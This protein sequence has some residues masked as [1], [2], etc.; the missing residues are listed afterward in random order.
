VT[1]ANTGIFPH[2][3]T[4]VSPKEAK[5]TSE[6][7]DLLANYPM[8][9][10]AR[11]HDT[12]SGTVIGQHRA[13][14]F[15]DIGGKTESFC[16]T[17]E[18]GNIAVGGSYSFM[19]LATRE[20]FEGEEDGA[21][22][23]S[24][25]RAQGWSVVQGLKES[26]ATSE[27][28]V[29]SVARSK[30]GGEAG[31][32]VS[33]EGI[34]GFLPRSEADLGGPLSSY[35][36]KMIP[37]KVQNAERKVER[38]RVFDSVTVSNRAATQDQKIAFLQGLKRGD[39]VRGV[40][41]KIVL[42]AANEGVTER[43]ELG[44]KVR[45]GNLVTGFVYRTEASYSRS[46]KP[47]EVLPVGTEVDATVLSIDVEK[48]ELKLSTKKQTV[49]RGMLNSLKPGDKLSGRVSHIRFERQGDNGKSRLF[50]PGDENGLGVDLPQGMTGYLHRFEVS[51]DRSVKPSSILPVGTAVETEV[52]SVDERFGTI[53][54]SLRPMRELELEA[55]RQ[56]KGQLVSGTVRSVFPNVG[57]FVRLGLLTEG[58][59]HNK[60]LR[61]DGTN[62]ETVTVGSQVDVR[63]KDVTEDRERRRTT[64]ALGR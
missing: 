38:G 15:V 30:T 24:Y 23:L 47:S 49:N 1:A 44:V 48:G 61:S 12:V 39:T 41:T 29:K 31:L 54:L 58:L 56:Q 42:E 64:V 62:R 33:L 11:P 9:T 28:R 13:G 10:S 37:V 63:I 45:I 60:E 55:L 14:F 8:P 59:L 5:M 7:L 57:Y 50:E 35:V 17:E 6:F 16:P 18:A 43:R 2:A 36:G 20:Y 26:R 52:V 19:V 25:R 32:I 21:V 27:V 51:T 34:D 46:A 22:R 40:V 3:S 53:K 4:T